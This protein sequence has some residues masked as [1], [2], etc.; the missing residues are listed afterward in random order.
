MTNSRSGKTNL[1][2][3]SILAIVVIGGAA[4]AVFM[5]EGSI[6]RGESKPERL[7]K[8][9]NLDQV[10][11]VKITTTSETITLKKAGDKWGLESRGGYAVQSE[12][13]KRLVLSL[14]DLK[15]AEKMTNKP[16]KYDAMG[17]GEAKP[18][19]GRV[20]IYDDKGA[21]LAGLYV[22][23]THES[24]SEDGGFN[25]PNGQYVRVEG[26]DANVYKIKEPITI[27]TM[28]ASWLAKD[29]LKVDAANLSRVHIEHA[30]TTESLTVAR[31]G[32][33]DFKLSDP[34][35]DDMEPQTFAVRGVSTA[36]QN[37][38][39]TDVL[40]ADDPKIK[41]L[42][43]KT[44]YTA[45]QK[46]GVTY[47]VGIGKLLDESYARV[48]AAYDPAMNLGLGDQRTSDSV[49]AK[50]M[51]VPDV[52]VKK[53]ADLTAGWVYK[54][55]Q[56]QADNLGKKR[57][58]LMKK[59]PAP[60]PVPAA[61]PPAPEGLS[62]N[63]ASAP[64]AQPMPAEPAPAAPP[65]APPAAP[66]MP[67]E[68]APAEPKPAEMKPEPPPAEAPKAEEP[69]KEEPAPAPAPQNP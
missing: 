1:K 25:P 41:D 44:T 39:L 47:N 23:K 34:I 19:N 15:P 35:P 48:R 53:V 2:A 36:I 3:L 52:T 7:F 24:P 10:A 22:G 8:G 51:E 9:L 68:P 11:Q 4:A 5:Q 55:A 42:D 60:T 30:G 20:Q 6:E 54:V 32:A 57:S 65:P 59:K 69:K 67:A 14:A 61:G 46:N 18:E 58:D 29:V 38:T 27:D 33:D 45:V 63:P 43:V 21:L 49:A 17:V 56:Y 40:R 16:E 64:P 28:P 12:N 62:L 13:L 26:K 50:A 37:L 66:P 31:I